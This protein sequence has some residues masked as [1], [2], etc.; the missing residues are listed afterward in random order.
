MYITRSALSETF[1]LLDSYPK[2]SHFIDWM[3]LFREYIY[4]SLLLPW[5]LDSQKSN[6]DHTYARDIA[7]LQFL[8][9]L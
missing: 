5:C 1:N 3:S 9:F 6:H 7:N 2:N 8:L 4:K